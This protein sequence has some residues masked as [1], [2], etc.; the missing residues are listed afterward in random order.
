MRAG[1]GSLSKEEEFPGCGVAA[2]RFPDSSR[3]YGSLLT[4]YNVP[5]PY[6]GAFAPQLLAPLQRS[7]EPRRL[8]PLRL[9]RRDKKAF[10]KARRLQLAQGTLGA[11]SWG[12]LEPCHLG[13]VCSVGRN[14]QSE[15]PRL[16][17]PAESVAAGSPHTLA[18][19]VVMLQRRPPR[20]EIRSAL[21]G[22]WGNPSGTGNPEGAARLRWLLV[23]SLAAG[24]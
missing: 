15:L 23:N 20:V 5:F 9:R 1:W 16:F 21:P 8:L 7:G 13:I 19:V 3:C 14:P 11:P 12:L 6:S 18:G 2:T 24:R 17:F 4:P 10:R 22:C